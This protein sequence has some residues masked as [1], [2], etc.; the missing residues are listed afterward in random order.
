[1]QCQWKMIIAI[2]TGTNIDACNCE[3]ETEIMNRTEYIPEKLFSS[4]WG[5]G[6]DYR[7]F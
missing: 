7:V 1:M 2:V 5:V 6:R 4:C 3:T